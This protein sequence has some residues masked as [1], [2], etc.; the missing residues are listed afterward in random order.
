MNREE[1][2]FPEGIEA[3]GNSVTSSH[4]KMS[5]KEVKEYEKRRTK[6]YQD[7]LKMPVN[8]RELDFNFILQSIKDE[9]DNWK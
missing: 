2:W 4:Y 9:N 3:W 6:E 1:D 5:K 8:K 7:W